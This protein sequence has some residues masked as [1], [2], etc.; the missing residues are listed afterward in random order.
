MHRSIV[1]VGS[2]SRGPKAQIAALLIRMSMDTSGCLVRNVEMADVMVVSVGEER[3]MVRWW[4]VK[5]LVL[6]SSVRESCGAAW[7]EMEMRLW[8]ECRTC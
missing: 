8:W 5:S 6:A 2:V 3:S 1:D 4:R 7:R